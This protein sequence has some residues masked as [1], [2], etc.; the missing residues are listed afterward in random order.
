MSQGRRPE[1]VAEAMREVISELLLHEVKDPRISMVTITRVDV[2]PDLR[3]AKVY[4]TCSGDDASR[5]RTAAG[6]ARAAGFLRSQLTRQLQLRYA[7]EIRFILDR[8]L[9]E[10]DKLAEALRKI[11]PSEE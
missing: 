6:L 2:A 5:Q 4:F 11:G 10:A 7:P 8:S 9:E 3:H 1:R